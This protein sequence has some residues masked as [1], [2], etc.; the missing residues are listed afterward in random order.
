MFKRLI[1][2]T[3][4]II[5]LV[6]SGVAAEKTNGPPNS[7]HGAWNVYLESNPKMCWAGTAPQKPATTTKNGRP[8]TVKQRNIVLFINYQP[9]KNVKNEVSFTGGYPFDKNVKIILDIEGTKF[10][11]TPDYEAST[12]LDEWAWPSTPAHDAKIIKEMKRGNTAV[13]TAQSKRGTL[14]QDSFSLKGFTAA[15]KEVEKSCGS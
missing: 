1:S 7:V 3:T 10:E 11:L 6:C 13:I 15:L 9:S 12:P 14:V 2:S 5:S 4:L 8:V